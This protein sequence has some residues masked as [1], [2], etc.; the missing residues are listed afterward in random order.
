MRRGRSRGPRI[1]AYRNA[2]LSTPPLAGTLVHLEFDAPSSLVSALNLDL[3]SGDV[4]ALVSGVGE[5]KVTISATGAFLLSAIRIVLT[6]VRSGSV[7][8][9][10]SD[11]RYMAPT[12]GSF[13]VTSAGEVDVV[14]NDVLRVDFS[15]IGAGSVNLATGSEI[16]SWIEASIS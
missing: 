10:F 1:R 7:D 2:A 16:G 11:R 3:V 6:R 12:G 8:A 5:V 15:S 14:R 4:R 13:S 9:V